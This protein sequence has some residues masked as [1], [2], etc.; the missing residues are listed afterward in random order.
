MKNSALRIA[1][2]MLIAFLIIGLSPPAQTSPPPGRPA[3]SYNRP[4]DSYRPRPATTFER[5]IPEVGRIFGER[6]KE[7]HRFDNELSTH[8]PA[9]LAYWNNLKVLG[10]VTSD[11]SKAYV[12]LQSHNN[13]VYLTSNYVRSPSQAPHVT[14]LKISDLSDSARIESAI[15]K[16]LG[17]EN[18]SENTVLKIFL[19]KDVESSEFKNIFSKED[20][21]LRINTDSFRYAEL[22]VKGSASV[23]PLVRIDRPFPPPRWATRFN[24]CCVRSGVPPDWAAWGRLEQIPFHRKDVQI[25]SLEL[26]SNVKHMLRDMNPQ[27]NIRSAE[28]LSSDPLAAIQELI[29]SG[30]PLSPIIIIGHVVDGNFQIQSDG[31][32]IPF[33]ALARS[34]QE[35][36]RPLFMMGCY[37]AEHFMAHPEVREYIGTANRLYAEDVVARLLVSIKKSSNMREFTE[38]VSDEHVQIWI[39]KNFLKIVNSGNAVTLRAPIYKPFMNGVKSIVG[40]LYMYIPCKLGG[41]CS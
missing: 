8:T 37:T 30:D 26:N 41:A 4:Y 33:D 11:I 17:D 40:F 35:A 19:D 12:V 38:N 24:K 6:P 36:N 16:I 25:V 27:K 14:V 9:E 20:Q 18:I 39:S 15:K 2:E 7:L 31:T 1:R 21:S 13:E 23:L 5:A 34:A 32:L 3:Y 22:Y 29:R 28:E 10:E